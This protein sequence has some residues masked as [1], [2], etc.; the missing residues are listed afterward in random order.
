[1][2]ILVAQGVTVFVTTHYMDEA[3]HCHRLA[4][5]RRGKIIATGTPD[6]LRDKFMKGEV[7][8][9]APDDAVSAVKVLRNACTEGR[10]DLNEVELYGSL[11]HVVAKDM[12]H[13]QNEI[14][15]ELQ[16]AGLDPGSGVII[17]PSLEDVFIASM[18]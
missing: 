7:L 11:V 13:K 2:Y 18:K 3:E 17:E 15:A 12:N 9:L 1:L 6:E 14:L 16:R 8:E 4:F 5:I 10:L